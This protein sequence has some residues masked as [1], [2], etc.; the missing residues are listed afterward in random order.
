MCSKCLESMTSERAL[1]VGLGLLSIAVGGYGIFS[2]FKRKRA[3]PPP[4]R[5]QVLSP[6]STE[7]STWL[8]VHHGGSPP[9]YVIP[10]L[11]GK[12]REIVL[13]DLEVGETLPPVDDR[14]E[15]IV[16]LGGYQGAYEGKI[17]PFLNAEMEFIRQHVARDTPILGI[18]LGCQLLAAA[19]G[20]S[21]YKSPHNPEMGLVTLAL[22][23]E[24][25]KHP[26]FHDF[27]RSFPGCEG[28]ADVKSSSSS[29]LSS[30]TSSSSSCRISATMPS[31]SSSFSTS[32][33]SSESAAPVPSPSPSLPEE[34]GPGSEHVRKIR[35]PSLISEHVDAAVTHLSQTVTDETRSFVCHHGDLFE[36][37]PDAQ[38]LAVTFMNN[39]ERPEAVHVYPQAFQIG[40]AIG[41]QF[42]VRH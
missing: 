1:K 32:S 41:V 29:S 37:P 10:F 42:H 19:T 27:G 20:G 7:S 24:G 5:R 9:G 4:Q 3:V 14:F 35:S 40:S 25:T 16:L 34:K 17:Y 21:A 38:L 12:G 8:I 28:P 33:S 15:G 2:L 6:K 11:R 36:A 31:S 30:S 18:C 13:V 26:M 23:K 22:T 39:K